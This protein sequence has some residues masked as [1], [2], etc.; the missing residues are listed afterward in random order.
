MYFSIH[1]MKNKIEQKP[2]K[3]FNFVLLINCLKNCFLVS[4]TLKYHKKYRMYVLAIHFFWQHN[5]PWK[6]FLP[7][8]SII[9]QWDIWQHE[10]IYNVQRNHKVSFI[11]RPHVIKTNKKCRFCF[12]SLKFMIVLYILAQNLFM[13]VI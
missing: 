13:N 1:K 2:I 9:R 6:L 5:L 10:S 7:N 11:V 3:Q 4:A 8:N 12:H